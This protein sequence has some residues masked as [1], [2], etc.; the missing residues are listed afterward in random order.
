MLDKIFHHYHQSIWVTEKLLL[1]TSHLSLHCLHMRT[2]SWVLK[3][4][5]ARMLESAAE[6]INRHLRM[7]LYDNGI[8]IDLTA[9]W[10]SLIRFNAV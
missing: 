1:V 4:S 8:D 3:Y 2:L 9:L 5:L 10:K 7:L 6:I